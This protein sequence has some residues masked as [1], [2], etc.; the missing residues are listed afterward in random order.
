M[1][2]VYPN[3]SRGGDDVVIQNGRIM[4]P[5]REL[6]TVGSVG[7]TDSTIRVFSTAPLKGETTID[8]TGLVVCPGFIDLHAH[9]Q[10][11]ANNRLQVLDG[12]TSALELEI[13]TDDVEGWYRER[14]GTSLI[15]HGVS[16][17][18]VPI[19][20]GLMGDTGHFVPSG[21]GA[22]RAATEEEIEQIKREINLGLQQGAFV[23]GLGIQYTPAASRREKRSEE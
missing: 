18:H 13:G 7:I 5:E 2:G 23:V 17:G 1:A 4:D 22:H 9:G 20:M 8:A 15:H 16:V 21:P 11:A 14:E 12:V 6:D 10:D 19:R 3:Q